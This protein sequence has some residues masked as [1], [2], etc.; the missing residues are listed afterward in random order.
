MPKISV[1][2][3]TF[4]RP[5]G[6]KS[7]IESLFTQENAPDFDIVIIDN[8]EKQSA[9]EIA[10]E[11]SEKA[12]SK[13]ITL[14]YD[15]EPNAGV[16]NARNLAMKH[17]KGEFIAFL[18]DDEVAFKNWLQE[19][20]LAWE[21]TKAFVVFGPIQARLLDGADEPSEYF[22]DFFSRKHGG[23][24]RIIEKAYGCGNSL[25]WREK[26]LYA[27]QPFNTATNETGGEDDLLFREVIASGGK[28]AWAANAWV[29][30]DVPAR[31]AT[32]NYLT[33]RAFAYGHNTTSQCFD[34]ANPNYINGVISMLRGTLQTL[35]MAP[36]A[37]FLFAIKHKKRA[38]AYD[39]MLRGLGKVLWFGPFKQSFY[40]QAA[41]KYLSL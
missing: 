11:L 6:L 28:F 32:Y 26:V 22:E 5:D 2:V 10:K 30:E 9:S 38:W 23:E 13:G 20:Y 3:P 18:D 27:A 31:R 29:Y 35:I 39:K 17:A 8:D 40:G 41:K 34:P 37:A 4:H 14:I 12:K 16:A 7:A 19:L 24:T 33:P 1:V 36:I 15:I 25:M 21:Q